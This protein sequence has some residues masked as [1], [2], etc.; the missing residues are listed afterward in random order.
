[1]QGPVLR[2][3]ESGLRLR[4]GVVAAGGNLLRQ[5]MCVRPNR[6]LFGNPLMPYGTPQRLG[7]A[8]LRSGES[9]TSTSRKR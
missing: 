5:E 7:A 2:F 6:I 9:A 1:M 8:L 3:L 4:P